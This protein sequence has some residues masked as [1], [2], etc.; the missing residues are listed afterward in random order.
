MKTLLLFFLLISK[1]LFAEWKNCEDFQEQWTHLHYANTNVTIIRNLNERCVISV[2][3]NHL[4]PYY[5]DYM[6]NSEGDLM[7]FV[8]FGEGPPSQSTGAREFVMLP[9]RE[10]LAFEYLAHQQLLKIKTPH[11]AIF[12]FD[13]Y[14]MD[15]IE[16]EGLQIDLDPNISGDNRAGVDLAAKQG[17]IIDVGWRQGAMPR[18]RP[19]RESHISDAFGEQCVQKNRDLFKIIRDASG[20]IDGARFKYLDT[21][22]L[23]TFLAESCSNIRL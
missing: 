16:V 23:T 5:R 2:H 15:P 8:S 10:K 22:Q 4:Y 18:T 13:V 1:P 12:T 19:E 21:Q 6:F 11:G 7:V 9:L 17:L 3:P 20:S 14:K